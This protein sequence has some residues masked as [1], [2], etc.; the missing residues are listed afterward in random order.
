MKC[1]K[2]GK[3][4]CRY[5]ESWYRKLDGKRI[6]TIPKER[7]KDWKRTNFHARCKKCGWAGEI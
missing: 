5:D 2:C 1:P 6:N 7:K 4:G 3:S